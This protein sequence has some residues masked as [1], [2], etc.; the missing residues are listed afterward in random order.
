MNGYTQL[1]YRI[2][3][4]ADYGDSVLVIFIGL[5]ILQSIIIIVG[6]IEKQLLFVDLVVALIPNAFIILIS[7]LIW[8]IIKIA[9]LSNLDP[10]IMVPQ[11]IVKLLFVENHPYSEEK[12]LLYCDLEKLKSIAE[13]EQSSIDWRMNT[14]TIGLIS[15]VS[16]V[17]GAFQFLFPW[18]ESSEEGF[19]LL[20]P[21]VNTHL[22]SIYPDWGQYQWLLW[23]LGGIPM[24]VVFWGLLYQLAK[25]LVKFVNFIGSETPNRIII[26]A[27]QEAMYILEYFKSNKCEKLSYTKK[28]QIAEHLGYKIVDR[29]T[30]SAA[31][32]RISFWIQ[33][34]E[35]NGFYLSP[36]V[37][38]SKRQQI[39][40]WVFTM[41]KTSIDKLTAFASRRMKPN[42]QARRR[43]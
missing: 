22:N 34:D 2:L 17:I 26:L 24:I 36:I 4:Y 3:P 31:E 30:I 28:K 10:Q 7:L 1:Y 21:L 12:G 16:L 13:I 9:F 6:A 23:L 8:R 25:A 38:P 19:P 41:M 32:S 14:V 43:K 33:E 35:S 11:Y 18:D 15:G 39:V 40:D 37:G 42:K 5:S 20:S 29:N 27:C